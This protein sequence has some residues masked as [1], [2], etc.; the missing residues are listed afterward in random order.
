MRVSVLCACFNCQDYVAETIESVLKQTHTDWEMLILDDQS[1]DS[2]KK[3]IQK[4]AKQDKRI[5]LITTDRKL[6]CGGAYNHLSGLATGKISAVLD[7]DD[8][9]VKSA[10]ESLLGAYE[11]TNADFIW[12]QFKICDF[13][14]RPIGKGF[15]KPP[16]PGKSLLE[17][18]HAFSHWRTYKTALRDKALIFSPEFKS[19]V[20]KWMGYAL[21]EAGQGY[22]FDKILYLYRR[23]NGGLSYKGRKNWKRIRK[24]FKNRRAKGYATPIPI[25]IYVP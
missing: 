15:S 2:S 7:S 19:A 5:K 3:I 10:M 11:A 25:K 23:R 4:Y 21:E 16:E 6:H 24:N 8:C 17:A 13:K 12:S 22:F 1:K 18:R 20:D 9:L 14:M